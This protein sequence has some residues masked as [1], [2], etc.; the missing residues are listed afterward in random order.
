MFKKKVI[1]LV[2]FVLLSVNV[3]AQGFGFDFGFGRSRASGFSN[4]ISSTLDLIFGGVIQPI[5]DYVNFSNFTVAVKLALWIVLFMLFST[6]FKGYF[7]NMPT[8]FSKIIA[9]IIA[10]FGVAFIPEQL[11][12]V[13]FRDFL[14]GAV[15]YLLFFAFI[16]FPLYWLYKWSKDSDDRAV[17]LVAAAGFFL[18]M[19]FISYL[20]SQ[21]LYSFNYGVMQ[22]LASLTVVFGVL[23]SLILFI[24]RLVQGLK[25]VGGGASAVSPRE[26]VEDDGG[27]DAKAMAGRAEQ[28][29]QEMLNNIREL[30]NEPAHLALELAI[31]HRKW[32]SIS[33]HTNNLYNEVHRA[34]SML[35]KVKGKNKNKAKNSMR[36][37][38]Q[39]L[40]NLHANLNDLSRRGSDITT[41][42]NICKRNISSNHYGHADFN[43]FNN[44]FIGQANY[45][46][47]FSN[48]SQN[49]DVVESRLE[50]LISVLSQV[51]S[52]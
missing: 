3:V 45:H 8:K 30:S 43:A 7:K 51:Q 1:F 15:G 31:D 26:R 2:M 28:T 23:G 21:L 48:L 52:L 13:L 24:H 27:G 38:E 44:W 40:I 4:I 17:N 46:H 39:A 20:D 14:S 19:L 50:D 49:L 33:R 42:I 22:N 32:N 5:F 37:L 36:N 18:M 47:F 10:F 25:G 9:A 41:H 11:L 16:F 34:I 29:A 12:Q 35:N 6:I